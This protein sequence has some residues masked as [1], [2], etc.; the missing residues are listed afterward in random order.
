MS[1]DWK[2]KPDPSEILIDFT[3]LEKSIS[4]ADDPQYTITETA[5]KLC[6]QLSIDYPRLAKNEK[7]ILKAL[8]AVI[9]ELVRLTPF[10]DKRAHQSLANIRIAVKQL[11]SSIDQSTKMSDAVIETMKDVAN[12]HKIKIH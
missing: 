2:K 11:V 3:N 8:N 12:G 4:N 6:N 1:I 7:L 10:I 5:A 9:A